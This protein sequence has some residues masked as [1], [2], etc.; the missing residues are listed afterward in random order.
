L[1]G[2]IFQREWLTLPR[3]PRHYFTR[4]AHLAAL[5]VVG[6]TVWQ[7]LFGWNHHATLGETSRF[8]PFLFHLYC[9]VQLIL[10][11]FF[12]ALTS[13]SAVAQEKDR[14]T[15]VLLLLTDLRNHEIVLGKLFGAILQVGLLLAISIPVMA[16]LILLGGVSVAAVLQAVLIMAASAL[17]AGSLGCLI[18]LWRERTF[19]S[20][21]LTVLF[22]VLYVAASVGLVVVPWSARLQEQLGFL[23][24]CAWLD[25][26][27]ALA[28]VDQQGASFPPAIGFVI[29]ML[30]AA[31]ALNVFAM[32]KLRKWNP[33]GEPIIQREATPTVPLPSSPEAPKKWKL[34]QDVSIHAAPGKARQVW[35]NPIL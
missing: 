23:A 12:A 13:A 5:W 32:M 30:L 14:R 2:P 11:L 7:L 8:A 1:L 20:L 4:A 31:A 25:P 35:S 33:S 26:F 6:V 10:L 21:A 16:L 24:W 27:L 18:A 22:L 34:G 28:S 17:V 9:I 29:V 19:Q 15:F 3:R